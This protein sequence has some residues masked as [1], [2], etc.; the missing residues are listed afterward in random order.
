MHDVII[1]G[2]GIAGLLCAR[3]IASAGHDVMVAEADH[4]IGTPEHCGGM[5]SYSA[6]AQLGI[7]PRYTSDTVQYAVIRSP[8]GKSI[9]INSLRQNVACVS[10]RDLDKQAARQAERQGACIATGSKVEKIQADG[11]R[12]AGKFMECKIIIDACGVHSAIKRGDNRT[13]QSAQYEV[14]AGWIKG[15]TVEVMLDSQKYPGF[16]AWVIPSG[17]GAGRV[18]AAGEGINP[19]AAIGELLDGR[20]RHSITRKIFAPVWVGGPIEEFVDGNVVVVGDAAGQTKPTT[21]GGIFSG[22]MGGILAGRAVSRYLTSGDRAELMT[23]QR[24]WSRIFGAEFRRQLAARRILRRL[25][26]GAI[27]GILESVTPDIAS[28]MEEDDFD[29]HVASIIKMLGAAGSLKAALGAL[30]GEVRDLIRSD[31]G[32]A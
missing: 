17:D 28:R 21:A 14:Y 16:F 25:G 8:S 5:V 23:Y 12:I 10:R 19:A 6:L 15:G 7:V 18:G 32:T 30:S 20:G 13:L 26:N 31:D 9:T 22:G 4:E 3:E 24:E 1:C 27:D 11:V 2:G 29:F